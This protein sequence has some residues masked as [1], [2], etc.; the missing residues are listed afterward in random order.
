MS[1]IASQLIF[2]EPTA[3]KGLGAKGAVFC[4]ARMATQIWKVSILMGFFFL[5]YGEEQ[6]LHE[7]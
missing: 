4:P 5:F 6:K 2:E 7:S 1:G 3:M